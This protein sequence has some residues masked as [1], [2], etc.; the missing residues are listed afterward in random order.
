M[1]G[2]GGIRLG[3]AAYRA[4]WTLSWPEWAKTQEGMYV[5]SAAA[6]MGL[7]LKQQGEKPEVCLLLAESIPGPDRILPPAFLML[8]EVSS[9]F[10]KEF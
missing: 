3:P 5:L 7:F 10:T 8:K 4:M 1:V 2:V 9:V 6:L